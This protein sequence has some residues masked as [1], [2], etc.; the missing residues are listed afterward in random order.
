[1]KY[2]LFGRKNKMT[3]V[4]ITITREKGG[5]YPIVRKKDYKDKA[6]ACAD[7]GGIMEFI[8]NYVE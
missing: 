2:N 1:M 6:E 5:E 7:V 8:A 4:E 3:S